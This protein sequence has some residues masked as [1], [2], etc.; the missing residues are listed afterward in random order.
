VA[1]LPNTGSDNSK[2]AVARLM[3]ELRAVV[4][5]ALP[6]APPPPV[7]YPTR[8]AHPAPT[9]AA[10]A[11][12]MKHLEAISA[13]LVALVEITAEGA[14]KAPR[15]RTALPKSPDEVATPKAKAKGTMRPRD[16]TAAQAALE[17]EV[18]EEDGV[19]WKVLAVVWDAD[20]EGV[21]VWYYDVEMAADGDLSEDEMGLS[22]T[23]GL[24]LGPLESVRA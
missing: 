18:F 17:G 20:E 7:P 15:R 5:R 10:V 13:A 23:E 12:H 8:S 6:R 4:A 21:V 11:F 1:D 3:A 14:F 22:R 16:P 19:D 24:D 9:R 2:A